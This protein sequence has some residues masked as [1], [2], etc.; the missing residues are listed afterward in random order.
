MLTS[1]SP[2]EWK[3]GNFQLQVSWTLTAGVLLVK[4][5]RIG[6]LFN[7]RLKTRVPFGPLFKGFTGAIFLCSPNT[8]HCSNSL[9]SRKAGDAMTSAN[10]SFV[11]KKAGFALVNLCQPARFR[12]TTSGY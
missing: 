12:L 4:L 10:G 2:L 7:C 1:V 9:R 5:V 3:H 8:K 6:I 11:S